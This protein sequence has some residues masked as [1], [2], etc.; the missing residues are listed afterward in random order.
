[1]QLRKV[2]KHNVFYKE[3]CSIPAFEKKEGYLVHGIK[4]PH[5]GVKPYIT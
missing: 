1:M 5:D 4:L 2:T 3:N